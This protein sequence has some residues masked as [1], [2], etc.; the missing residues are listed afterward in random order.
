MTTSETMALL[1][2][3]S[4]SKQYQL[5]DTRID[6]LKEVSLRIRPGEFVAVWGP[7]G[8]GKSTLCN[9][10]GLLDAPSAGRVLFDGV[11]TARL[12]DNERSE[13]RNRNIGFV[14]Q[15][16]NLVPVL[17][18][19]ENIMLPL[20]VAHVRTRLART[21]AMQRLDELGLAG[22]AHHRPARL[23]GG[24]QQRVAIA[25]ALIGSPS[26]VIADEPTANL[27]SVNALRVI[28]LM[29][30]ISLREGTAFV[31]STHDERLLD[32]V[33]RRLHMQDG[34]LAEEARPAGTAAAPGKVATC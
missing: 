21:I 23:S 34:V 32:R 29:R 17:S 1:D 24:Q 7:S 2:L 8:S 10:A 25:R 27:D 28:A 4:V 14:F 12:N 33:D 9:L 5:G 11:D 30:Q 6:A 19:L 3:R 20:Q 26:L 18:A 31:F 15:S 22:H 13:V 16:F